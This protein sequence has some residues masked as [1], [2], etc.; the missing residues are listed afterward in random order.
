[1]IR[2]IKTSTLT[3]PAPSFE[4]TLDAVRSNVHALLQVQKV[5]A[6]QPQAGRVRWDIRSSVPEADAQ[7]AKRLHR[8]GTSV[9][10]H[11]ILKAAETYAG[12]TLLAGGALS[13]LLAMG[14]LWG[15]PPDRGLPIGA[16]ILHSQNLPLFLTGGSGTGEKTAL[17]L[18]VV[19]VLLAAA[20][21]ALSC[22]KATSKLQKDH[23]K[24]SNT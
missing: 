4:Q 10:M 7:S 14:I 9:V 5:R 8:A 2:F 18:M 1:M 11:H 24:Q 3:T 12:G 21:V 19:A 13:L 23:T 16:S 17:I 6:M 22:R 15:A 20:G